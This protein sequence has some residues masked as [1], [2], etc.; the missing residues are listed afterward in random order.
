MSLA[1]SAGITLAFLLT[2]CS[3]YGGGTPGSTSAAP[4][5]TI[6]MV[7]DGLRPDAINAT[8]TPNL[9]ALKS[10]GV[11]FTDNHATY[12]TFTMMNGA[13]FATGVFPRTS[14]F[15]GNTFWT[16]PQGSAHTIPAGKA[17]SGSPQSYTTPVFTEDYQV[18]A[19]LNAYYGSQLL[20]VKS[21]FKAAQDAGLTTAAIGKSGAA[22]IQ[23][24]ARG[25][26]FVDEN[27]VMPR[28]LV[29]EL[30]A[31]GYA[32]PANTVHGYAGTDA[33]TLAAGNGSPT[34]RAGYVTFNTSQFDPA[35]A[36]AV[37]ARDSADRTQGAPEDAANQYMMQVYT[38][39]ILPRKKPDLSVIWFRTPD[40]VEHGYGPGTANYKA[41]LRSQDAR[42]GELMAALRNNQ[43]DSSTNLVVVSD[44]GHSSVSGPV[45]VFPL[46]GITP[47]PA[48]RMARTFRRLPSAR[49][50]RCMAIRSR[51]TCARRTCCGIAASRPMTA[52]DA[53]PRPWQASRPMARPA[54]RCRWM[55]PVRSAASPTHL[56][57]PSVPTRPP[58]PPPG[59]ASPCRPRARWNPMASWSPPTVART[60]STYQGTIRP[61]SPAW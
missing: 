27:T 51:G 48:G 43:L 45:S 7:W 56:T 2:G 25:G 8:D 44:H 61:R 33:V 14:G 35:G 13:S 38:G 52:P 28:G 22:Y 24:L 60:T 21:L 50:I 12:P 26:Y 58:A 11:E 9:Y 47:L 6:I 53:P 23:D 4:G 18:L 49:R 36:I 16:P 29:T 46:L 39:Y 10:A 34:A 55:P 1:A 19:T 40:N 57:W 30:Q 17:A 41:G 5:R 15:Y 59:Q 31:A 37:S 32:L 3:G 20:L 54:M 42:L